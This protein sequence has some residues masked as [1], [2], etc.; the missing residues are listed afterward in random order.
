[1]DTWPGHVLYTTSQVYYLSR[2]CAAR[3][4]CRFVIPSTLCWFRAAGMCVGGPWGGHC[5]GARMVPVFGAGK[6]L[7]R[8]PRRTRAVPREAAAWCWQEF[9]WVWLNQGQSVGGL[10]IESNI[11]QLRRIIWLYL[12]KGI[13][14]LIFFSPQDCWLQFVLPCTSLSV[15]D[16]KCCSCGVIKQSQR[17]FVA[18]AAGPC[19]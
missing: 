8:R 6:Q 4:L 7:S 17:I 19:T 2:C 3:D 12:L 1:M 16:L 18:K 14:N 11:S 15:R 10:Y 5:Q 9:C 13:V